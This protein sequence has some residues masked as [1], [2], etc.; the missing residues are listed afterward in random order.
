MTWLIRRVK[1]SWGENVDFSHYSL[2]N[3]DE[4]EAAF[5]E[6]CSMLAVKYKLL[7]DW[8]YLLELRIAS[9]T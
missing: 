6:D 8:Q 5:M 3:P 7:R 9:P 4:V 1:R 2:D